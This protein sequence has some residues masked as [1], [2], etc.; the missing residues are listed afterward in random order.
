MNNDNQVTK[1]M[2]FIKGRA[3]RVEFGIWLVLCLLSGLIEPI[4]WIGFFVMSLYV[5]AKRCHDLGYSGWWQ[6]LPFFIFVMLFKDGELGDNKYG[7]NPKGKEKPQIKEKPP[8]SNN[9]ETIIL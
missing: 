6:F 1:S 7:K 2:F 5:G 9:N 8:I 3:R 4:L